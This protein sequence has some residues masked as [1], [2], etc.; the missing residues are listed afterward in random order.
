MDQANTVT[1]LELRYRHDNNASNLMRR[2]DHWP[3]IQRGVPGLWIHTGLHPDSHTIYDRPEKINYVKMEKIGR[4]VYQ[5]AWDLA[6]ASGRPTLLPLGAAQ[7]S[8][9]VRQLA[10]KGLPHC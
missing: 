2:S 7:K 4:L 8:V 5:A 9:T 6:N 10:E 1:K 3:F